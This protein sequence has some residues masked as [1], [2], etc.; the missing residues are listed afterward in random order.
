MAAFADQPQAIMPEWVCKVINRRDHIFYSSRAEK[1]QGNPVPGEE[2][3]WNALQSCTS[4]PERIHFL[5]A[6]YCAEAVEMTDAEIGKIAP[7]LLSNTNLFLMMSCF[8]KLRQALLDNTDKDAIWIVQ[9][10]AVQMYFLADEVDNSNKTDAMNAQHQPNSNDP[11]AQILSAVGM[12][13]KAQGLIHAMIAPGNPALMSQYLA[14][15]V[16]AL[17]YSILCPDIAIACAALKKYAYIPKQYA[18][19]FRLSDELSN[20]TTNSKPATT[21]EVE[22]AIAR[23]A[24]Q[25]A[26]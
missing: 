15:P 17:A 24:D 18:Y 8:P 9:M 22:D 14:Q 13:E 10:I 11:L 12:I 19:L 6:Q 4:S 7:S 16:H 1:G 21:V 2:A 5:T 20:K 26:A 25:P 23:L 3:E